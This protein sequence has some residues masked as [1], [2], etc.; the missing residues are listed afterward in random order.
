MP[1]DGIDEGK[2]HHDQPGKTEPSETDDPYQFVVPSTHGLTYPDSHRLRDAEREHE[3]R[4]GAGDCDLVG[5]ERRR[6]DP[7]H[8][9]RGERESADFSQIL[10]SSR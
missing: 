5:G 6:A 2:K 4:R 8:Q 7:A 10:E 1:E 3:C 9:N